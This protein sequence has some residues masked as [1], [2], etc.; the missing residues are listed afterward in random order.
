MNASPLAI[1]FTSSTIS[2]CGAEP[3]C[4]AVERAPARVSGIPSLTFCRQ[5]VSEGIPDTRAGA[6]STAAQGGSAPQEEIVLDV[7]EMAKGLAFMTVNEYAVSRDGNL[8]AYTYDN[9]GFRQ[10]TLAVK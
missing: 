2:S 3:P 10:Y 1:S 5:K 6:R 4:A 8:L 9:T 7:N